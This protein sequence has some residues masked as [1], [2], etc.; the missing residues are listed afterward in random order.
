M[1][2]I[3]SDFDGTFNHNGVTDEKISMVAKWQAAGNKVGVVSGRGLNT[4]EN[5]AREFPDLK[6][7]FFAL[8]NG[9]Y[10]TDGDGVPFYRATCTELHSLELING[11]LSYGC[12]IMHVNS[13]QYTCVVEDYDE[14]P[15]WIPLE[16]ACLSKDF[17][18][19]DFFY[20]INVNLSSFDEAVPIVEKIRND[21]GKYVTP[22]QN[23]RCIDIV[24]VGTNK[25]EG[26]YRA[27]EHF[28]ASYADVITVGDNINDIDMLRE[29][30]SYAM[31][32]GV[33]EAQAVANGIVSD[34]T[35]IMQREME[36]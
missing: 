25:A 33:P 22:L 12:R 9:A 35:E 31:K 27:M 16:Q 36:F 14:R 5:F 1:K 6:F 7:D 32:N 23:G 21:Y 15:A 19:V 4:P 13:D 17:K 18:G 2:I 30:R 24:P 8:C 29:F 11:L 34:V 10:V 28:G 26:M 3:G 20:Q